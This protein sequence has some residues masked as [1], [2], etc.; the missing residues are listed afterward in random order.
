MSA[1]VPINSDKIV[2]LLFENSEQFSNDIYINLMSLMKTYHDL[3]NNRDEIEDFLTENNDRIDKTIM[4]RIRKYIKKEP[5]EFR[6][7][8]FNMCLAA[9]LVVVVFSFAGFMCYIMVSK[10]GFNGFTNSTLG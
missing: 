4:K 2:E 3:E 9:V 1:I 7:H 8:C 10:R 5:M 6:C